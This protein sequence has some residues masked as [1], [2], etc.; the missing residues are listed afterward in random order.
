MPVTDRPMDGAQKEARI[1]DQNSDH[2]ER[3]MSYLSNVMNER[4]MLRISAAVILAFFCAAPVVLLLSSLVAY[5]LR[6]FIH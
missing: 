6:A 1:A 4:P 3:Q 5:G 2:R